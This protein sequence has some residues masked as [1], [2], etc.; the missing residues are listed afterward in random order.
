MSQTRLL[1][2]TSEH[3]TKLNEQ[4][5]QTEWYSFRCSFFLPVVLIALG[6]QFLVPQVVQLYGETPLSAPFAARIAP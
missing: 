5:E 4:E 2:L 3:E 1:I 6:A